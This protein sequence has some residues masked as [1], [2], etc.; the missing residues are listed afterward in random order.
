M[1]ENMRTSDLPTVSVVVTTKNEERN[2]KNCLDSIS[3]Q[4]YD[5]KKIEI[6]VIDNKST[7]NTKKIASGYTKMV[8]DKGH[9][10]SAQRNYGAQKSSGKYYLYLDA[11]MILSPDVIRESVATLEKE[12][13]VIALYIPEVILGNSF[14]SKVRKFERGFYNGT[15]I[16]CVR[17]IRKDTFLKVGGFDESMSGPE[18]WDLD[19]KIRNMGKVSITKSPIYHNES[20]FSMKNYL[21]KKSYYIKSFDN[22]VK[23][24][25]NNDEDVK[26]Q[27]GIV[28][29]YL[30][31]FVEN[32]KWKRLILHPILTIGM[33]YLRFLVG[34]S[35]LSGHLKNNKIMS[36]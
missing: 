17:I 34:I 16:D 21:I 22:Y 35:Y 6:I 19:K 3:K 4:T 2:I 15:A 26:K 14:W 12:K 24:W 27:L 28:Y 13:N 36:S 20:Q 25:G 33:L 23:K 5:Q 1:P 9:E 30:E 7:D 32:N 10:R 11:D 18:D 31:V 29:R 8:F